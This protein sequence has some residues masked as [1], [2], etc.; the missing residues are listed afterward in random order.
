MYL[1]PLTRTRPSP[2]ALTRCSRETLTV[3][4]ASDGAISGR[5]PAYVP[6]TSSRDSSMSSAPFT[7][8]RI[9]STSS[10][11]AAGRST[12]PWYG[13][14]VVPMSQWRGHG[15]RN[16]TRP[17]IRSVIPPRAGMRSR[18]TTRWLPSDGRTLNDPAPN[19]RSG[20]E[21]QTPVASSTADARASK[22]APVTTSWSTAPATRSPSRI[23]AVAR[24]RVTAIAAPAACS[25]AVRATASA[26]RASSSIASW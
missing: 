19:G 24:T 5:S 15:T 12:G 18:G 8:P 3:V 10:A 20:I 4:L 6:T 25:T 22:V 16:A 13:L 14:S 9:S 2:S 17:G 26:N 11:L 23:G 21:P 1:P 7:V